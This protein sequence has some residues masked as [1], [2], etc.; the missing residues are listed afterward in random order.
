MG[1]SGFKQKIPRRGLNIKR[2]KPAFIVPLHRR[3]SERADSI[4]GQEEV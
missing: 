1:Y 3:S 4:R 2:F